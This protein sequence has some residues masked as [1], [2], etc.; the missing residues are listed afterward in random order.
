MSLINTKLR[1]S[2]ASFAARAL[3][4]I[5]R[6]D[7]IQKSKGYSDS[8]RQLEK[9]R[10]I[11]DKERCFIVAT[12]PSLT[13]EDIERIKEEYT[14]GVNTCYKLFDKTDWRPS[15][16][17]ISDINVYKVIK[18]QL[19]ELP[20][21]NVFLEGSSMDCHKENDVPF[22]K[23]MT[24]EF[25]SIATNNKI[26]FRKFSGD[27]SK[28]VDGG[29]SVVYIALQLAVTMGFT[30][31]YLIGVD[32]NYSSDKKHSALVE[33]EKQPKLAPDA[34]INMMLC[35]KTAKEYADKLGIKILNATRG[36]QLEVFERVNLDDIVL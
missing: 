4:D 34:E 18:S 36:G 26:N 30:E 16:Y 21:K 6:Y 14:F 24:R 27:V 15:Y 12:G 7:K 31:I 10:G 32:C 5:Y 29:A 13:L 22:F 9:Y 23:S 25:F 19:D 28:I 35:F 20:L 2:C 17:C 8:R 11:H 33:Y 3:Y 1:E